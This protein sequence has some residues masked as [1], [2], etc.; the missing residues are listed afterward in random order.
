MPDIKNVPVDMGAVDRV[1]ETLHA[2]LRCGDFSDA[3]ADWQKFMCILARVSIVGA[4]ND[5]SI[6]PNWDLG[7]FQYVPMEDAEDRDQAKAAI[8]CGQYRL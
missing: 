6:R 7:F 3:P 2:S 5:C 8:R 4:A 1:A